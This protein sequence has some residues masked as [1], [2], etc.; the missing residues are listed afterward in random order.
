MTNV[1]TLKGLPSFDPSVISVAV[2]FEY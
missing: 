2:S 1:L